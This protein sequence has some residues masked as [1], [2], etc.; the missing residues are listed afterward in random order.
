MTLFKLVAKGSKLMDNEPLVMNWDKFWLAHT[1]FF[2]L[3][4]CLQVTHEGRTKLWMCIIF[5]FFLSSMCFS[6]KMMSIMN[7]FVHPHAHVHVVQSY[8]AWALHKHKNKSMSMPK[9]S[10]FAKI[11]TRLAL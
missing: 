10:K 5:D 1:E 2:L 6:W 11:I 9:G 8:Y 3:S 4:L 7:M